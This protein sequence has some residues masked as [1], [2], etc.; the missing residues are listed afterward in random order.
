M[1]G[2]S[3]S[4]MED[5]VRRSSCAYGRCLSAL[6]D[7]A[8]GGSSSQLVRQPFSFG[9]ERERHRIDAKAIARRRW[10]VRKDVALVRSAASTHDFGSHHAVAGIANLAKIPRSVWSGKHRP[11]GAALELAARP[12][13]G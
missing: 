3:L 13:Q 1:V 9:R 10:A 8:L 6:P 11:A 5:G 12:E 2:A 4:M 7:L